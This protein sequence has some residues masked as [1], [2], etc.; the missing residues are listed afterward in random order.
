MSILDQLLNDL[1]QTPDDWKLRGVLADWFEDNSRPEESACVRWMIRH[2][3]RPYHGSS[4]GATWFNAD[5][6]ADGLG[7]PESDIPGSVF[8]LLE[9]GK[10]VANHMTFPN[11]RAAEEA[12]IA[13]WTRARKKGWKVDE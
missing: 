8:E 12:F 13:G 7:D 10:S 3:K 11:V 4:S 1:G 6:V 2:Q 9:G 5:T